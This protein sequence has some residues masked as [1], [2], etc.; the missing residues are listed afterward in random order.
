MLLSARQTMYMSVLHAGIYNLIPLTDSD[1]R[2]P[3]FP[4]HALVPFLGRPM[5][6]SSI[7]PLAQPATGLTSFQFPP[8]SVLDRYQE[9]EK[10]RSHRDSAP[11]VVGSSAYTP[12]YHTLQPAK[13]QHANPAVSPQYPVP[14]NTQYKSQLSPHLP[15]K[16]PPHQVQQGA[17]H[18]R[19]PSLSHPLSH[20]LRQPLPAAL[21]RLA[22]GNSTK[23]ASV[24]LP[25]GMWKS[26]IIHAY[27]IL[28]K[29]RNMAI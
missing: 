25:P 12:V 10:H 28:I 19:H 5:S 24:S 8:V 9:A 16:A 14:L 2:V 21:S 7:S 6:Q 11:S 29:H 18:Y 1:E 22:G 4:W 26:F 17:A 27:A 3:V 13:P 15:H 20:G 23:S